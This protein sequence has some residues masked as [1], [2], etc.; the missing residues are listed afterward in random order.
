[1]TCSLGEGE[2]AD[3]GPPPW[4]PEPTRSPQ[5]MILTVPDRA[6]TAKH[7]AA[8]ILQSK[9]ALEGERKQLTMLFALCAPSKWAKSVEWQC[10][11]PRSTL[12]HP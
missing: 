9:Y 12:R 2:K 4:P 3:T 7:L 5:A 8:K 6:Y 11:C 10:R 1:M